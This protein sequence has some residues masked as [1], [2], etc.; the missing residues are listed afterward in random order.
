M[1]ST[2]QRTPSARETSSRRCPDRTRQY[3]PPSLRRD[4]DHVPLALDLRPPGRRVGLGEVGRGAHHGR[5]Q[6]GPLEVSGFTRSR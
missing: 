1:H 3:F 2:V 5:F 6:A 4:V